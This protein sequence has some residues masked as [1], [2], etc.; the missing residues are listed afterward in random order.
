[1][2]TDLPPEPPRGRGFKGEGKPAPRRGRTPPEIRRVL[3]RLRRLCEAIRAERR[4]R[5]VDYRPATTEE[6]RVL[7][8]AL[9]ASEAM[10]M[11]ARAGVFKVQ[12]K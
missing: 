5:G 8:R 11:E 9:I 3:R 4:S 1:M 2:T 12:G 7:Y 6:E 10:L